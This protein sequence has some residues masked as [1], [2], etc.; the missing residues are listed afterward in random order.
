MLPDGSNQA[1]AFV[2][3]EVQRHAAL[4]TGTTSREK[5]RNLCKTASN[6]ISIHFPAC[7]RSDVANGI[8]EGVN[9]QICE[10]SKVQDEAII[11]SFRF[12]FYR[13]SCHVNEL[14]PFHSV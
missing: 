13:T 11:N 1:D 6:K 10:P 4:T 9:R 2:R 7:L 12:L 3:N 5:E 14:D 8:V